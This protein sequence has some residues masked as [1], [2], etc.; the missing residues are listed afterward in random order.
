MRQ[1][2]KTPSAIAKKEI[3]ELLRQIGLVKQKGKCFF[4]G[5]EISGKIHSYCTSKDTKDGH[6]IMQY[7]HLNPREKN[8]SFANPDLGVVICQGVHGWKSFSDTNKKL[9]DQA[10]RKYLS[11][12]RRKLWKRVEADQ[13]SY[14]MSAWD[15]AKEE[16]ALIQELKTLNLSNGMEKPN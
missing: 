14:P 4:A 1:T 16:I 8:V 12:K 7:D 3:Q 10:V 2:S 13:K 15:W 9:Y 6:L 11:P 5:K